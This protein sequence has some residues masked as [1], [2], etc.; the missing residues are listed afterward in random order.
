MFSHC[1]L[2]LKRTTHTNKY[3]PLLL[4]LNFFVFLGKLY[5]IDV[6]QAVEPD[7]PNALTFL[8]RDCANVCSFFRRRGLSNALGA[9]ALFN[10]VT[11]PSLKDEDVGT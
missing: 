6:S 9:E 10:F 7:H 11:D 2:S 8:R 5:F 1:L 4:S 3:A